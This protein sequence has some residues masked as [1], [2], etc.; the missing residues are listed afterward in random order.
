MYK[1]VSLL[2]DTILFYKASNI[3]DILLTLQLKLI[4]LI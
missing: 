1:I 2:S 3:V 4:I